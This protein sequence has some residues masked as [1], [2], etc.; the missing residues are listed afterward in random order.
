MGTSG[1]GGS[2]CDPMAQNPI[3]SMNFH[4]GKTYAIGLLPPGPWVAVPPRGVNAW[5]RCGPRT[6][7]HYRAVSSSHGSFLRRTTKTR[8]KNGPS[9][10]GDWF[11]RCAGAKLQS[12]RGVPFR[13]GRCHGSFSPRSEGP[14]R[15]LWR[16]CAGSAARTEHGPLVGRISATRPTSELCARRLR[17]LVGLTLQPASEQYVGVGAVRRLRNHAPASE[18][19]AGF[20]AVRRARNR[21]PILEP[22]VDPGTV[23]AAA[24]LDAEV[25]RRTGPRP[26]RKT[27][28]PR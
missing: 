17:P 27:S 14:R 19:C 13:N 3:S 4:S 16:R 20:G 8:P 7:A 1:R 12:Q 26:S 25:R 6:K 10:R 5:T 9:G 2:P 28:L 18:P 24:P 11:G 23:P 15:S 21:P 22:C